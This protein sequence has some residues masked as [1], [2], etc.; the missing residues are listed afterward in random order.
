MG[1]DDLVHRGLGE[2]RLV[3]FVVPVAAITHQVD[4][5]VALERRAEGGREPR[6]FDARFRVVG[7]DVENRHLEAAHQA[8]GVR[9]GVRLPRGGR[10]ADLVVGDDV[11]RAADVVEPEPREVQRLGHDAL[12]WECG[13]AV[14]QHRQR[15]ALVDDRRACGG[16]IRARGAR[17]ADDHGVDELEMARIRRNRDHHFGRRFLLH[18]SAG[19]RVV[20][21]VAS[22]AQSVAERLVADGFLELRQNL[23]VA[24]LHHVR[25]DIQ[26]AAMRHA[27]EH[28]PDPGD[29]R[30]GNQ[31]V[32]DRDHHV[33]T[34][35][36]KTGLAGECLLEESLEGLHLGDPI[37]QID[38]EHRLMRRPERAGL[39][40][41][42]EP[43]ALFGHE[44]VRE[45]E[46][47]ART[48]DRAQTFDRLPRVA[49]GFGERAADQAG[50]QLTQIRFRDA[51]GFRKQR[52]VADRRGPQRIDPRGQVS[53]SSN[54][55]RQVHG[56]DD[57][58]EIGGG[59]QRR[60]RPGGVVGRGRARFLEARPGGGIDRVG[61][62]A[63]ALVQFERVPLVDPAKI[64]PLRHSLPILSGRR[65]S[66]ASA[67][68]ASSAAECHS[69]PAAQP[70]SCAF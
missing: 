55:L 52:R 22:P 13:I 18:S 21:H 24:L 29:R 58:A 46:A 39:H 4:Q 30:I 54:R 42:T 63:E 16:R 20:L 67:L 25:Q 31:L 61:I 49:G 68:D 45:I 1:A 59:Q 9:G 32:E 17:H 53:V 7:I 38:G 35:D 65:S 27:D 6:H 34:F 66:P 2:G 28:V 8:T 64:A 62:A 56:A 41:M 60:P 10:E 44:D 33:Q 3:P 15:D 57:G 23:D 12:A 47:D 11:D 26:A 43:L 14:N 5:R 37:E 19:A 50:R 51:V 40:M 70:F 36:R 48:V 69:S